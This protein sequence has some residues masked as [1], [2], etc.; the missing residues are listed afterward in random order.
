MSVPSRQHVLRQ[1]ESL[2]EKGSIKIGDT[3]RDGT[4][5]TIILPSD[6]PL[7]VEKRSLKTV[8]EPDDFYNDPEKRREVYE[9]DQWICQYCG[10]RVS[11]ENATLDHFVPQSKGGTHKK[12]NLRT[13]CLLCNSIKSGK[14]HEEAAM[15]LLKSIQTRR[16]RD[17]HND[18]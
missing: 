6:V 8:Q 1:L 10:E 2:E 14:T 16:E 12:E 5:Y 17:A 18:S 13:A 11:P 7:V 9:R 15:H 3:T 4:L